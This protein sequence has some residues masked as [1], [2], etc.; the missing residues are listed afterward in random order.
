MEHLIY[1]ICKDLYGIP[2]IFMDKTMN[3]RATMKEIIAWYL[4][5]KVNR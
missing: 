5:F 3:F 1:A 4:I 2:S